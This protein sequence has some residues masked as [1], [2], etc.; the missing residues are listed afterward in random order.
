[1]THDTKH[2]ISK[3]TGGSIPRAL[4]LFAP[5]LLFALGCEL[6]T[7]GSDDL[8]CEKAP[9]LCPA[10]TGGALAGVGGKSA[11]GGAPGKSGGSSSGGSVIDPDLACDDIYK[12]VCGKDGITYAN[13]C[14]AQ[15]AGV[16]VVS[17]GEC[18]PSE[19]QIPPDQIVPCNDGYGPCKEGEFCFYPEEYHCGIDKKGGRCMPIPTECPNSDKPVCGCDGQEYLNTC[20]ASMNSMSAIVSG[21]CEAP[22]VACTQNGSECG[23]DQFCQFDPG[24]QCGWAGQAGLCAER[25]QACDLTFEPVCGCDQKTYSNS[26]LAANAGVSVV[27]YGTCEE[28]KCGKDGEVCAPGEVCSVP[29]GCGLD[30]GACVAKPDSCPDQDAPVCG[31]DGNTYQNSCIA[32]A[33]GVN[34][35]MLGEC[36][37]LGMGGAGN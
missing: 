8:D 28:P 9:E 5:G 3:S 10:G 11:S 6:G 37:T 35:A 1:M 4:V 24:F 17:E 14:Y 22:V 36:L 29:T 19:P 23:V 34:T 32:L 18:T 13:D 26:C 12:P 33:A 27:H 20:F 21:P 7:L 25:P 30:T 31:C 16:F 15:Q 2:K